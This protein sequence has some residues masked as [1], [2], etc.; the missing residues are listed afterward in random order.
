MPDAAPNRTCYAAASA[1]VSASF[2]RKTSERQY[3]A[4]RST[5]LPRPAL[6]TSAAAAIPLVNR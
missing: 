5:R 4:V 1:I 2:D 6:R 3:F